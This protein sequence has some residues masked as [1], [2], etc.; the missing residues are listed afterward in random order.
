MVTLCFKH[1]TF[2]VVACLYICTNTNNKINHFPLL[3]VFPISD[4]IKKKFAVDSRLHCSFNGIKKLKEKKKTHTHTHTLHTQ[5][6]TVTQKHHTHNTHTQTNVPA[7][8]CLP[9]HTIS[10][11]PCGRAKKKFF[12]FRPQQSLPPC[13][14]KRRSQPTKN[15]SQF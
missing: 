4:F 9:L 12:F 2:I 13:K 8:V 3:F 14:H 1:L 5:H 11:G 7:L 15:Y 10:T 6:N